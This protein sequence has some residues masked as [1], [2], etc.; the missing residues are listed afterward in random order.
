MRTGSCVPREARGK[1]EFLICDWSLMKRESGEK[2]ISQEFVMADDSKWTLHLY[3]GGKTDR[4]AGFLTTEVVLT[5]LGE[6]N[7]DSLL[8]SIHL[9]VVLQRGCNAGVSPLG[10]TS[11]KS[12]AASTFRL[13][14]PARNVWAVDNFMQTVEMEKTY[15]MNDSMLFSLDIE[16]FGRPAPLTGIMPVYI[17][18]IA[19]LQGDL[20]TL[21]GKTGNF[22]SD[23]TVVVE[24]KDYYCHKC[25]LAARSQF[26]KQKFLSSTFTPR[27]ILRRG[28]YPLNRTSLSTFETALQFIYTDYCR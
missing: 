3:L 9:S 18:S 1:F 5:G 2:L 22:F 7:K 12:V 26:F 27:L 28:K 11:Y 16:V 17:G 23:I 10:N 14:D 20:A 21:Q 19:T 25:I 15:L 6:T 8:A 13:D 4:Q 24:G